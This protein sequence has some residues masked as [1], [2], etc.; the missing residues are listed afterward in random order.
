MTSEQRKEYQKT[1][2]RKWHQENKERMKDNKKIWYV[3]HPGYRREGS[4]SSGRNLRQE[5][6]ELLGGRCVCCQCIDIRC[7]EIDHIIPIG[8]K[9]R[10]ETQQHH[11]SILRGNTENLQVLC[12]CCH[13]IKTYE[14][15][16]AG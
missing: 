10:M 9:K 1:Y 6:I 13:A 15:R 14:E 4:R 16:L 3:I 11:R 5:A 8:G 7:L 2:H 12:A